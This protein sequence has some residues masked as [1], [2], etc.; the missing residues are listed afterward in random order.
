M[1]V[2]DLQ[3]AVIGE[4]ILMTPRP[5]VLIASLLWLLLVTLALPSLSF[6]Q[7]C[8]PGSGPTITVQPG[9]DVQSKVNA[10]GCG[11]TLLFNPGVY[12]NFSVVPLDYDQFISSTPKAAILSGATLV[13]NFVF[14]TTLNLWVGK[15]TITPVSGPKGQCFTGVVGCIHP[16]DL[17]FNG[18]LYSR[19][20]AYTSV[21]PGTWFLN[22]NSGNV[23]LADNPTGQNVQ[24]ST[25][26]FAIGGGNITSV[27][28]NGFIIEHYGN[29][30]N[31][32]AVE[33]FDYY[34][35]TSIPSF[36]WLVEN[37]E[38]RY[39]HGAG[40]AL[41]GQMTVSGNYL[42][43][44]G[45][46]GV[47]GTGNNVTV[48]GNEIAFNN[49]V[50]YSWAW[51]GGAKFVQVVGLSVTRNYSH[52]NFG[53]GL[54]T[55]IENSNVDISFN[56]LSNNRGAGIIHEISYGAA[57]HDNTITNDGI[58]PRGTGP[59]WGGGIMIANSSGVQVYNNTLTNCQ[60]GIMEQSKN[61][62]NG[63]NGLPYLLENVAVYNNN[64]IQNAGFAAGLVRS[65]PTGNLI[66]TSSGNTFG[67]NNTTSTSAP[68][69][70]TLSSPVKF[71]WLYNSL[72]NSQITY[73]QWQAQGNN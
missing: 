22:Y 42:H 5:N 68:N 59:W 2:G 64:I 53:A 43:H 30:A 31:N 45:Q 50:K 57:I 27:V 62:G 14:N 25:T 6:G 65:Y 38:I 32:G 35:L 54:W 49:A 47:G 19:V 63:S 12:K 66:Y 70:Y 21:V 7:T 34:H 36:N 9:D 58:D 20:N 37:S 67:V 29:P 73:S 52:D 3:H 69:T 8:S 16:E 13:N 71:V 39:N 10:A 55:D 44:N 11:A 51:A 41:G 4:E 46:L 56:Q 24:I 48:T 23:Y 60:N 18:T 1:W 40:I 17:F 61:R 72:P 26:R 33:G 15:I 28:I